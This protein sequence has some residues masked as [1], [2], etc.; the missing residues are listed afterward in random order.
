[1]KLILIDLI[2]KIFF[3]FIIT[4]Q[5]MS[6]VFSNLRILS[7]KTEK[8]QKYSEDNWSVINKKMVYLSRKFHI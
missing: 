7:V 4:S 6:S 3:I 1:M 8:N 2:N 5:M